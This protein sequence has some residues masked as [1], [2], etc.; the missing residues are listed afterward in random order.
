MIRRTLVSSSMRFDLRVQPA[1]RVGDDEVGAA[2]DGRI[3]RVVDDGSGIR[4]GGVGDDLDPGPI[5]PDPELV[6]GGG[7]ERVGGGEDD[8]SALARRSARPA[9]RSSS[10]CRSR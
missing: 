1:G 6:D 7:A 3:E 4:A 5:G 2:G 10:S 9:C 8:R